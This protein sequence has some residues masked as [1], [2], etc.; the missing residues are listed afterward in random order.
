MSPTS[1]TWKVWHAF[2]VRP[3]ALA[4]GSKRLK[5]KTSERIVPVHPMLLELGFAAYVEARQNQRC[6]KLFPEL[7]PSATGYYS[8]AFSKWF[9]RF[10]AAAG[11]EAPRTCF[12]SFRHC[13][14]DA[15]RHGRVEHEV[16]LALG[17]WAGSP[18]GDGVSASYGAGFAPRRLYDAISAV[19]YPD[20][21]L[22]HLLTAGTT[23]DGRTAS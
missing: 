2:H 19:A 12:H 8:D 9:R 7:R 15:L 1:S 23:G 18:G 20:L 4:T 10:L 22:G 6:L 11:A 5:T 3:D 13:F 21:D 16:G 14:R 17:G